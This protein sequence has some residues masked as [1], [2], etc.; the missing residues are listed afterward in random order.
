M[1]LGASSVM[2]RQQ[3]SERLT[4]AF[5]WP[6]LIASL[7]VIPTIAIENAGLGT[8]WTTAAKILNWLI[9]IAFA[10]EFVVL[11]AVAPNRRHWLVKHPLE[12]AI[13]LLTPPFGPAALQ[14]ARAFRLLRLLRLLRVAKL[15]QS[16]FSMDAVKWA[17]LIAFLLV[18]ACGVALVIVEGSKHHPHLKLVDGLWWAMTTVT[19]IG[20]GDIAPVTNV[21]RL[22]AMCI[23]VVGLGFVAIVT[24]AVAQHFIARQAT[25][26]QIASTND[27]L[28][29][30]HEVKSEVH[31]LSE[32]LDRI[33]NRLDA[34]RP[35]VLNSAANTR[36]LPRRSNRKR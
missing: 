34:P 19:T 13:V 21:G 15:S 27:I 4:V 29:A 6:M 36:A 33:E 26:T 31:D 8:G 1:T 11:L 32:R 20:Y 28:A 9:W 17:A 18:E 3:R 10:T 14:S 7:L 22:M 35:R 23:M 16:L 25:E 5:E 12:L 30:V 2:S 24:G